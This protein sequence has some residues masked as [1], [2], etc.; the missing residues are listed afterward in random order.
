VVHTRNTIVDTLSSIV[1][2]QSI[3]RFSRNSRK[4]KGYVTGLRIRLRGPF[5]RLPGLLKLPA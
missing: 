5:L 2:T 4:Q 1:D 3:N